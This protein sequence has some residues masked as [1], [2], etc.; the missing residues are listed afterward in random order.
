MLRQSV[1]QPFFF[2]FLLFLRFLNLGAFYRKNEKPLLDNR[3]RMKNPICRGTR[4][5]LRNQKKWPMI[6]F[7]FS[8][9]FGLRGPRQSETI[10]AKKRYTSIVECVSRHCYT[11]KSIRL[12]P[13]S[14]S[15]K[16]WSYGVHSRYPKK[17]T[18]SKITYGK[19]NALCHIP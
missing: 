1:H 16:D 18:E 13:A 17:D 3:D 7:L 10:F 15:L 4:R 2:F 14:S 8:D 12:I 11:G 19:K 5:E 9:D 6:I